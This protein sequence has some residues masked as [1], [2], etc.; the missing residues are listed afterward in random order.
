[1]I[2]DELP[3]E[4]EAVYQ[5]QFP[6]SKDRKISMTT[7]GVT[8]GGQAFFPIMGEIQFSRIPRPFWRDHLQKMKSAGINVIATYVFWI[9]HEE[10]R[11]CY[12]W[13]EGRDL[14]SFLL[15]CKEM[16]F[17]I[18]LR[19]GPW[20]H[21]EVRNGGFPDWLRWGYLRKRGN[22]PLYLNAVE[23]YFNEVM[24]QCKDLS[25]NEGGPILGV[26]L[27][28]EFHIKTV[29]DQKYLMKLKK[30]VIKRGLKVPIY[31]LTGWPLSKLFPK[32]DF[33]PFWG[34]YPATPWASHTQLVDR[35][36]SF[37]MKTNPVPE[38]IGTDLLKRQKKISGER[39]L[40][41]N[42]FTLVELGVANQ[43]SD[44]RRPAFNALDGL[45]MAITKVGSGASWMGY[46]MF[47]G[48]TN[49]Y[50]DKTSLEEN[51]KTG[52][53]NTYP[54]F[55]YDFHAP[56]G[57][58]GQLKPS[59][60]P[61]KNLHYFLADYSSHLLSRSYGTISD[62]PDLSFSLR[63]NN[64][65]EFLIINRYRR[66]EKSSE[67]IIELNFAQFGVPGIILSLAPDLCSV[68][69]IKLR[70]GTSLRLTATLFPLG[71]NRTS[72][73][74]DFY[75]GEIPG[76]P[77]LF[78]IESDKPL[79]SDNEE[80][81]VK[82]I[83]PK[84]YLITPKKSK[85]PISLTLYDDMGI[86]NRYIF[87]PENLTDRFWKDHDSGTVIVGPQ[88]VAFLNGNAEIK[89]DKGEDYWYEWNKESGCFK[90]NPCK[91]SNTTVTA[92]F[93]LIKKQAFSSHWKVNLP[94]GI[95]EE[96]QDLYLS[97]S[98][99]GDKAEL[100]L[101]DK[102]IADHFNQGFPWE[103]SLSRLKKIEGPLPEYLSL[104]IKKRKPLSRL[105]IEGPASKMS[106]KRAQLYKYTIRTE[107]IIKIDF[108]KGKLL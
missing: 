76:I 71:K 11:G 49:P 42:P 99:E 91:N 45:A 67:G 23:Q 27:E 104:R 87:I 20:C 2:T 89:C 63:G 31:A 90:Q 65:G 98:Y 62:S 70:T 79:S 103:V 61:L 80:W 40:R 22:Y 78:L 68:M 108:K 72:N 30:M 35:S 25:W 77:A 41:Q 55:S 38:D 7:A 96:N 4:R 93:S 73:C 75:F 84:R 43:I 1:M 101:A 53:P 94:M 3:I 39:D 34:D 10:N 69:P 102:M 9:H 44:K 54:R 86:E 100:F 8:M 33:L 64:E 92:I 14:S 28:N 105:Y 13:E 50:G 59:Y 29:N 106:F 17:Y 58:W 97:F 16:G 12:R 57:E 36:N 47:S 60:Y 21:G 66:G 74:E 37:R 15:L 88:S 83:E 32:E 18:F 46:Y 6:G 24:Q 56:I 48:G 51:R 52:Y 107:S 5:I 82:S 26:Q 81:I 95:S 85:K 19:I